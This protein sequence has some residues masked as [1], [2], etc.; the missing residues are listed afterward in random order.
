ME[1]HGNSPRI[2]GPFKSPCHR[3]ILLGNEEFWCLYAIW[4]NKFP[5]NKAHGANMGPSWGQQ[6]PDGPH[7]G[8]MNFAIWVIQI[9]DL[10][11]PHDIIVMAHRNGVNVIGNQRNIASLRRV[12]YPFM[13]CKDKIISVDVNYLFMRKLK[14][15]TSLT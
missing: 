14:R 10:R 11:H 6:D 2:T 13:M 12:G 4:L 15:L 9:T 8:P 7:V 5:D 3:G 1:W